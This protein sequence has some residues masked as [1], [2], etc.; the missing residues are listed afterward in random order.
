MIGELRK[1]SLGIAV[2]FGTLF[3]ST[4]VIQVFQV[5]QLRVDPRN[6]RTLYESYSTERGSILVGSS[7]IVESKPSDDVYQIGRAHV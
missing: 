7:V 4:T 2:L 3:V 1:V 5:D 6:V